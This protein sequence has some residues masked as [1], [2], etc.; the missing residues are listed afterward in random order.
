MVPERLEATLDAL[1]GVDAAND[2][3]D[4]DDRERDEKK[5]PFEDDAVLWDMS[6]K[7]LNVVICTC[8][9]MM[10]RSRT[11]L[12]HQGMATPSSTTH[13]EGIFCLETIS[14]I[15]K[16]LGARQTVVGRHE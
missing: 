15:V 5:T 7:M 6:V 8:S 16:C 11:L 14:D 1:R 3:P 12:Y 10:G 4:E 13:P 9:L 2:E